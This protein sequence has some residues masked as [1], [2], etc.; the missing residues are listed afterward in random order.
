MFKVFCVHNVCVR[1]VRKICDSGKNKVFMTRECVV[2]FFDCYESDDIR[3]Y[4]LSV[5][6][7]VSMRLAHNHQH[8]NREKNIHSMNE[9]TAPPR[10]TYYQLEPENPLAYSK[11]EMASDHK[12]FPIP[13]PIW[14]K[15]AND[16]ECTVDRDY[17]VVASLC[18]IHRWEW[19]TTPALKRILT[20]K[21]NGKECTRLDYVFA[22]SRSGVEQLRD[23]NVLAMSPTFRGKNDDTLIL[24]FVPDQVG[25]S[26]KNEADCE[27]FSKKYTK[28]ILCTLTSKNEY[29]CHVIITPETTFLVN[30]TNEDGSLIHGCKVTPWQIFLDKDM[31]H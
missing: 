2:G 8:Y 20:T 1:V 15:W 31:H 12:Y 13:C 24:Y 30:G 14:E 10:D 4:S 3:A 27:S 9:D 21:E 11:I 22:A 28:Q 26:F 5:C 19:N 6:E 7:C 17:V 16:R 18:T 29:T 23:G 25:I